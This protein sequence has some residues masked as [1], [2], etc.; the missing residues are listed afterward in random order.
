M[1]EITD[2]RFSS[3]SIDEAFKDHSRTASRSSNKIR[4]ASVNDLH[5]FAKVAGNNLV[6]I[7]ENDF[8]K[9]GTDDEGYFIERLV[10]DTDGPIKG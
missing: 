3:S 2:M 4:V 8:W 7:S 9:L 10:D 6:R 1:I 5:G